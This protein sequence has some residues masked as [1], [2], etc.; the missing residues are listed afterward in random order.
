MQLYC[1]FAH[2]ASELRKRALEMALN[3]VTDVLR[4]QQIRAGDDQTL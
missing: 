1:T 2:S 3:G 4:Q